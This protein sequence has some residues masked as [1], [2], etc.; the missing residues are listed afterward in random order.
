MAATSS[1]VNGGD[2][3]GPMQMGEMRHSAHKVDT[4]SASKDKAD[5]AKLWELS[6]QL[7]GVEYVF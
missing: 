7:T 6:T 5:A 2:Y 3:F 4:T 1:D